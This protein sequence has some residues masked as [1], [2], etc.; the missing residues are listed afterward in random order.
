MEW[1]WRKKRRKGEEEEEEGEEEEE[2]AGGLRDV[3]ENNGGQAICHSRKGKK[4]KKWMYSI[5]W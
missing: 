4:G 1:A 5:R 3:A 2:E